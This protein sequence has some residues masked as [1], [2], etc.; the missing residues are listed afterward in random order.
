MSSFV[1]IPV[2]LSNISFLSHC[3]VV[4]FVVIVLIDVVV[5][6]TVIVF[7][8]IINGHDGTVFKIFHEPTKGVMNIG[9][10]E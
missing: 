1:F 8:I 2:F 10:Y 4:V 7:N 5:R 6:V 3:S 9:K